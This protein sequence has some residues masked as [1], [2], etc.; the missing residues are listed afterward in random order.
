ML[1]N[2]FCLGF[3]LTAATLKPAAQLSFRQ[4]PDSLPPA[5]FIKVLPQNFY[6]QHTGFFCKREYQL[7]KQTGL[8]VFIR[9]GEKTYVD[10]LEK[11]R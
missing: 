10:Y 8:N 6:N 5:P 7:Q 4:Y 3:F 2:L 1:P 9:L 11:K